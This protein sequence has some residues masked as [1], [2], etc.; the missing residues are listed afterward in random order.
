[1]IDQR[2]DELIENRCRMAELVVVDDWGWPCCW[3][4]HSF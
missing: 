3:T 4:H 2:H 1:V